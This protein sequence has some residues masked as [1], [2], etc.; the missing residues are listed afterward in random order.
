MIDKRNQA[1]V[2]QKTDGGSSGGKMLR[3]A[4]PRST[5]SNTMS[6][7][8]DAKRAN[9][10][11]PTSAK[12]SNGIGFTEKA[13]PRSKKMTETAKP[14][15]GGKM[16]EKAKPRTRTGATGSAMGT[17]MATAPNVRKKYDTK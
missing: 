6:V 2:T 1:K 7:A 3:K 16:M 14:I 11:R 8:T 12:P 15:S 9:A 5:R 17:R 4:T 10:S 13:K